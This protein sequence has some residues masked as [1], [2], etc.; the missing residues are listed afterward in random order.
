[1]ICDN[2]TTTANSNSNNRVA[3]EEDS[4][5]DIMIPSKAYKCLILRFA[6]RNVGPI[7]RN[8]GP[9]ERFQPILEEKRKRIEATQEER[10]KERERMRERDWIGYF[11]PAGLTLNTDAQDTLELWEL[12]KVLW[13]SKIMKDVWQKRALV[14]ILDGHKAFLN[15]IDRI[16]SNNYKPTLQDVLLARTKTTNVT[17]QRYTIGTTEFELYDVGGQRKYRNKWYDTFDGV[18]GVIFVAAL[19][20]YDQNLTEA[21]RTNRLVDTLDLFRCICLNR[22]FVDT[23]IILFLN[24]IDLVVEKIRYSNIADQQAFADYE[25][26]TNQFECAIS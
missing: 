25:S 21:K 5:G 13:K 6:V 19:S 4:G 23:P 3:E 2:T 12:I 8:V 17:V 18:D 26:T 10:E 9:I 24:K 22:A 16:V 7:E 15:D 1:M 14:N 20:E 11:P